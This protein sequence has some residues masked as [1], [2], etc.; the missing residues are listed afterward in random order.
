MRRFLNPDPRL[1]QKRLF[2]CPQCGTVIPALK[3]KG[4]T[5]PGHVKHMYCFVCRT[6][7]EHIQIE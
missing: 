1:Y 6:V 7:T 2:Q 4:K 5:H 3:R